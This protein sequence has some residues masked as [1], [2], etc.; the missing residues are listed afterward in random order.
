MKMNML[1]KLLN[2]ILFMIFVYFVAK[3]WSNFAKEDMSVATKLMQESVDFPSISIC[4]HRK[5]QEKY[6]K[7]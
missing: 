4:P 6:E 2:S 3:S 1:E 7:F 5:S